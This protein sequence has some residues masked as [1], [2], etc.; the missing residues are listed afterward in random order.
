MNKKSTVSDVVRKCKGKGK[1]TRYEAVQEYL[2]ENVCQNH[3]NL[4]NPEILKVGDLISVTTKR[5]RSAWNNQVGVVEGLEIGLDIRRMWFVGFHG[6][7]DGCTIQKL[8]PKCKKV[9]CELKFE[10][11]VECQPQKIMDMKAI[12]E[13]LTDPEC[14]KEF[15]KFREDRDE[16]QRKARELIDNSSP[17]LKNFISAMVIT[18]TFGTEELSIIG[19]FGMTVMIGLLLNH[20]ETLNRAQ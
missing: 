5:E 12:L 3:D 15:T 6:S 7:L 11:K 18:K 8:C 10:E 13:S 14:N 16:Y 1:K 2:R 4:I 20:E 17:A 9:I 19:A